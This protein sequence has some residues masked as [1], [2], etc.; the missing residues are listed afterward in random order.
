M[1]YRAA[2][3]RKNP[4]ENSFESLNGSFRKPLDHEDSQPEV[5][6]IE[7]SKEVI[8]G[9]Q[10][11]GISA[12]Q[13]Q[14]FDGQQRQFFGDSPGK[15]NKDDANYPVDEQDRFVQSSKSLPR[16]GNCDQDEPME[17]AKVVP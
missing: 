11:P 7:E 1:V 12:A 6:P 10:L 13:Q 9:Q 2:E 3:E 16:F 14:A 5:S 17:E 8:R 15:A 4:E